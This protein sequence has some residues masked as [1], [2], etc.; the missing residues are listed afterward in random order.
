MCAMIALTV[1]FHK[2]ML[3]LFRRDSDDLRAPSGVRCF[4]EIKQGDANAT[5][6]QGDQLLAGEGLLLPTLL[7]MQEIVKRWWFAAK[8]QH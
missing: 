8:F 4:F 5:L 6:D 1:G 7:G 2:S 3:H